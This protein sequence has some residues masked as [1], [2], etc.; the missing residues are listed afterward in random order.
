M[1]SYNIQLQSN[2]TGL[3]SV[4]QALQNKAAGGGGQATP[5]ISVD[6]NGLIIATAGAKTST[7]QLAFQPAKTIT[8]GA[9]SQIAVSAEH[10]TGGDITVAG[11]SNLVASNI[12]KD[13]SIFGV[14]G[15]AQVGGSTTVDNTSKTLLAG[16]I[17]TIEDV[18]ISKIRDYAFAGCYSLV[19]VNFPKCSSVGRSA[20]YNCNLNSAYLPECKIINDHAFESC[21]KLA[22]ADFPACT[23]IGW[24]A[25]GSCSSLTSINFPAC[26]DIDVYAFNRCHELTSADFPVCTSIAYSAFEYCTGLTSVNFPACVHIGPKAFYDCYSLASI[27]FPACIDIDHQAFA[28]CSC[29]TLASF[30]VCIGINNSAFSHCR[31]LTSLLLGAPSVCTLNRS[32]AFNGTPFGGHSTLKTPRIYVPS[33]LITAY[34][35]AV[36]WS[37]F[38]SYFTAIEDFVEEDITGSIITF[39]IDGIEYQ[40]QEG[41]FWDE[42]IEGGYGPEGVEIFGNYVLDGVNYR[43]LRTSSGEDVKGDTPI[44]PNEAYTFE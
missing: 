17:T 36:N 44:I 18:N 3:Q 43:I 24:S 34:Q 21:D 23:S 1:S 9:A 19:S 39:T 5:I 26:T 8:P 30:P 33:S 7:H 13:V 2:N 38:S 25:F 14:K 4:L 12:K 15:T 32:D 42:W 6:S 16:T 10:Y 35:T 27:S 31:R 20:F 28:Y 29:L 40:T 41:T 22:V 37:Y 11:D